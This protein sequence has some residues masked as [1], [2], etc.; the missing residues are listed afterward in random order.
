MARGPSK[1]V[2]AAADRAEER[3]RGK[4]PAAPVVAAQGKAEKKKA[5]KVRAAVD[6]AAAKHK[7]DLTGASETP[8][9]GGRPTKY[10]AEFAKQAAKL[11]HLG[12]T[13]AD[14]ADFFGVTTRTIMNWSAQYPGFFHALK[15]SKA[16][17]DNR[18]VRSLYQRAIG[19]EYDAVKIFQ[20]EGSP[21]VVPYREKV[22]PDTVA[23]I[24]WL[25]NRCKDEW[26]DK[27]EV[28]HNGS[29]AFLAMLKR[30]TP[31]GATS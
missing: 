4:A 29:A 2:K 25:K 18:V 16:A 21:V 9:V 28:E 14:L 8:D 22:A 19:Y 27:Q 13:D 12:A 15:S 10:K 5:R 11:C 30:V 3:S 24:F 31:Q 26:R 1:D 17:A 23:C 6:R 20:Y 7:E